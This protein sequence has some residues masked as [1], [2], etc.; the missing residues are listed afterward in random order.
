[1]AKLPDL[2]PRLAQLYIDPKTRP[3]GSFL[4]YDRNGGH[5]SA[6]Y[7]L[8]VEDLTNKDRRFDD[9]AALGGKVDH[10]DGSFNA[11][12]PGVEKPHVRVALW[13]MSE[14]DETRLAAK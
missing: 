8:P 13:H 11:C 2:L 9:L 5:A 3:V 10:V 14:G 12:H 7:M 6:A 1:M 4:A